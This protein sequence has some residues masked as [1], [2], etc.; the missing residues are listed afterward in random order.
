MKT[1]ITDGQ[2]KQI[3]RFGSDAI[4][5]TLKSLGLDKDGAQRVIKRGDEF[6]SAMKK[7]AHSVLLNLSVSSQYADEETTSTYGYLS[8][9]KKPRKVED[10]IDILRAEW[11]QLNPDK[12]IRFARDVYQTFDLPSWVEGPG[13]II[14]PG[15]FSDQYGEEVEEILKALKKSYDGNFINYLEDEL[16]TE[17]LRQHQRTVSNLMAIAEQQPGDLLVVPFQFGIRYPV[18]G[19]KHIVSSVRRAREKFTTNEFGGCVKNNGTMLMTHTERLR[20]Y[21]DLWMDC[22]GDERA[23]GADGDFSR[24]PVLEFNGGHGRLSACWIDFVLA[25]YSSPSFLRPQ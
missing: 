1:S 2:G 25:R 20:N 12:A 5:A 6:T 16:G 3:V 7:A 11:P 21:D 13:V 9:Y 4:E 22:S 8:G 24:A 19:K 18:E 17:Y 23:P 14:R 10:Q 15:Y